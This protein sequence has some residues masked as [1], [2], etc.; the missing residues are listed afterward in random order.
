MSALAVITSLLALVLIALG[1]AKVL[2]V[3]RMRVLAQ[4]VGFT[5]TDYRRIGA[6]EVAAAVGLLLGGLLPVVGGLAASGLLVLLGGALA[7]HVRNG[8]D[9]RRLVP[10]AVTAALTVAYLLLLGAAS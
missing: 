7:M 1:L 3:P 5:T 10:A 8:D 2:A 4:H 6:L 9:L